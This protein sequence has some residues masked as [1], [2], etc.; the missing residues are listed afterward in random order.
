MKGVNKTM[1]NVGALTAKSKRL[2]D[3]SSMFIIF[4]ILF[5]MLS[6]FVPYFLTVRNMIG[7]VC[8]SPW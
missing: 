8:Q 5:I 2:W 3:T 7:L 6:L 4:V 1:I